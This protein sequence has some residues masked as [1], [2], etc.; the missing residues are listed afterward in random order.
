M[1]GLIETPKVAKIAMSLLT[2][3]FFDVILTLEKQ[4]SNQVVFSKQ[5]EVR[6]CLKDIQEFI[7]TH[8]YG[9]FNIEILDSLKR[10]K[11]DPMLVITFKNFI[12][13]I[14]DKIPL[15]YHIILDETYTFYEVYQSSINGIL[16]R[17]KL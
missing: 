16:I 8:P 14:E 10:D 4:N 2:H 12:T 9:I 11:E 17:V 5:L 7:L 15:N 1:K 6:K 3:L 13:E